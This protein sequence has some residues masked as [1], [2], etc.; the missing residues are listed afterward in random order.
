MRGVDFNVR[1]METVLALMHPKKWANGTEG[2]H[3]HGREG[4]RGQCPVWIRLSI[5]CIASRMG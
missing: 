4:V 3:V 5:L 1:R 2:L